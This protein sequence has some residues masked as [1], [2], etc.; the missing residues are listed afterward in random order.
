MIRPVG[1]SLSAPLRSENA[2][3][4]SVG[5]FSSSM[6]ALSS[7]AGFG[8]SVAATC[9]GALFR[10]NEDLRPCGVLGRLMAGGSV[11]LV[12]AWPLLGG[13]VIICRCLFAL[14]FMQYCWCSLCD[15]HPIIESSRS[16][17]LCFWVL[18]ARSFVGF[19]PSPRKLSSGSASVSLAS[20]KGGHL[21]T[22]SRNHSS[23]S[24]R[25]G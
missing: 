9:F 24:R 7:T 18:G 19:R 23:A 6:I 16:M 14:C 25:S 20:S 5:D 21:P 13:L 2:A 10:V 12:D 22:S 3:I 8:S 11:G 15:V 4:A 17:R 1:A